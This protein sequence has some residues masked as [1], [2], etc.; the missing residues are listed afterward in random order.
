MMLGETDTFVFLLAR[1]LGMSVAR[2][3]EEIGPAELNEWRAFYAVEKAVLKL[4]AGR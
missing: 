2:L 4:R 3:R 1:D